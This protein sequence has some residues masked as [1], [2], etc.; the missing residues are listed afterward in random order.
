MSDQRWNPQH[1]NT[2]AAEPRMGGETIDLLDYWRSIVK[3]K[4]AIIGFGLAVALSL[5][6]I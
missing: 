2:P 1:A 5:I 6:H 4:K 3:R